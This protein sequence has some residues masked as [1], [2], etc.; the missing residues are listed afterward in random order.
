MGYMGPK[1]CAKTS[2]ICAAGFLRA[3][4]QPGSKGFIGRQDYN[5]LKG[6]TRLRMSE[7]LGRLPRGIL[8]D[9]SKD[10]PEKWVI[11]T[12]PELSPE[13]DIINDD[14]SE[15]TFIGFGSIE[16]GGSYEFDWGCIDEANEVEKRGVTAA[17]GWMRN[18]PRG[19]TSESAA[20]RYRIMLAFNPPDNHHWLYEACTGKDGK[21]GRIISK[22]W[23]RL[24]IP[25]PLE[26]Q[27]NLPIDY[28][29]SMAE[30]MTDDQKIRLVEGRWGSTFTGDPVVREFKYDIHAR[31]NLMERYDPY[32]PLY[33][34]WDF[35][36]RRPYIVY[37]QMDHLGRL[38]HLKE[39][40]GENQEI[41]DFLTFLAPKQNLWFPRHREFVDYGDPAA[42]QKKDTGSTLQV[43]NEAGIILQY[44]TGL[45]IEDGLMVL[46][47]NLGKIVDGEPLIQ[48]DKDGCSVLI[49]A[50]RGGYRIDDKGKPVKDGY[51]DHPVDADRY[52]IT[53]VFGVVDRRA[54]LKNM[55]A[56]LEY[57]ILQD[58][59]LAVQTHGTWRT[60]E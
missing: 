41:K 36:Y 38:L 56:T 46:R 51:F 5:D 11:Q 30:S 57:N 8:L 25:K 15:I 53:N 26:N 3:L 48:Y 29:D 21:T 59:Q 54:M 18:L 9:R 39:V 35:G 12:V 47:T 34:F 49:N 27:R 33:R 55:P 52:G 44:R 22:P 17:G 42:R 45:T 32:T 1:G 20:G 14:P 24:Y 40:M 19:W 31:P 23:I 43:L 6:T 28:Y 10:P 50:L 16:E 37:C 13:G 60:G 2:T 4:L 7:M 58:E